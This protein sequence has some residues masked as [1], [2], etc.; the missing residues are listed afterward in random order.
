[1]LSADL[2]YTRNDQWLRRDTE[3]PGA[4]TLGLT[5]YGAA[6]LGELVF[7]ELPEPG[8]RIAVGA[9]F[10]VVESVKAVAELIS[11]VAG[12]VVESNAAVAQNPELVNDS[13]LEQG[14]IVRLQSTGEWPQNLMNAEQY[15]AFRAL[16]P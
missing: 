3:N 12:E 7:A 8:A 11:P 9:P 1:M 16:T 13:P 6:E 15:A 4:L 14:W 5:A 10:G 2:F